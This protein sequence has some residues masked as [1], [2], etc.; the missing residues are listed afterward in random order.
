MLVVVHGVRRAENSGSSA[1]AVLVQVVDVF[2][3]Q[4]IDVFAVLDIV[5]DMPVASNDWCFGLTEQKTVCPQLLCSDQVT[6]S[7]LCRSSFGSLAGGVFPQCKLCRRLARSH[8]CCSWT[9]LCRPLLYNDRC[10][11]YA[12]TENCGISAV[13]VLTRWSMSLFMQF[14]DGYGRPCAYA[15]TLGLLLEVLQTQFIA[16]AG[17]H[18]SCRDRGF[19]AMVWWR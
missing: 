11:G 15:A 8:R 2:F 3:V 19:S 10:L 18:S 12:S 17:G 9:W 7:L 4:F 16:R 13:A 14:I 1:V 6:M 5:V